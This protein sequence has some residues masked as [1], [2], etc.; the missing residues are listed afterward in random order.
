MTTP[1]PK[2]FEE[3]TEA[4]LRSWKEWL[5]EQG[6]Q[7]RPLALGH[8]PQTLAGGPVSASEFDFD[9]VLNRVV[10]HGPDGKRYIVGVRNAELQ[11]LQELKDDG[12]PEFVPGLR[13]LRS[14]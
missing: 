10:E 3:M 14:R 4:E 9:P 7:P 11:R 13:E 6:Q 1:P 12:E 2:P 5:L 8:G